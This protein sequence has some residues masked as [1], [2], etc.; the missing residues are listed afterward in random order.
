MT[1]VDTRC[2]HEMLPGQ[3][4]LCQRHPDDKLFVAAA[5]RTS[6]RRHGE[7][8]TP[9]RRPARFRSRCPGLCGTWIE[10]GDELVHDQTTGLWVCSDCGEDDA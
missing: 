9:A 1:A 2:K 10:A 6:S 4:S 5:L 3:C 7:D 8:P